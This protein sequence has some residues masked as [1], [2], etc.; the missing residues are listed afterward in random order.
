M[1]SLIVIGDFWLI[2]NIESMKFSF[3][4]FLFANIL[5]II[6][7]HLTKAY[8]MVVFCILSI[9]LN[10]FALYNYF[11]NNLILVITVSIIMLISILVSVLIFKNYSVRNQAGV[12]QSSLSEYIFSSST[13]ISLF[14]I[15][16]NNEFLSLIGFSIWLFF[17]P[18]G[19][20][21]ANNIQSEGLFYQVLFYVPIEII[22]ITSYST[23]NE[24]IYI[25]S[26]AIIFFLFL[27]PKIPLKYVE[28]MAL[29]KPKE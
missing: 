15:S 8:S 1:T 16:L 10:L 22:A 9:G 4:I 29:L 28:N 3:F 25:F 23:Q 26:T 13:I 17:T 2:L 6:H 7:F 5:G 11:D 21:V 19:L 24:W 27:Y 12:L 14:F 20:I 18:V